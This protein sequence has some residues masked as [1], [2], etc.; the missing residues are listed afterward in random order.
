M[1]ECQYCEAKF[2]T[3]NGLAQH[4]CRSMARIKE[5][6]NS[7]TGTQAFLLYKLWFTKRKLREPS[8]K[9]FVSSR[10]YN[11]FLK[12]IDFSRKV[13][14]P[15][16]GIYL[17]IMCSDNILPQ[18]WYNQ[19]IYNLFKSKFDSLVPPETQLRISFITIERVSKIFDC[20]LGDIFNYIDP[21]DLIK[22][23]DSKNISPWLLLFSKKFKIY[24][25][26]IKNPEHITL[27]DNAIKIN[28]WEVII[29]QNS[30]SIENIKKYINA[31][32]L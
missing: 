1:F 6:E 16:T 9:S 30:K 27:L 11:S 7:N 22:L 14:I 19:D 26:T 18:H 24:T 3:E 20:K 25:S 15:D 28:S 10:Y 32:D 12:F 23:I 2:Q 31:A 5:L 8:I 21:I 13:G 17:D 4:S 29:R